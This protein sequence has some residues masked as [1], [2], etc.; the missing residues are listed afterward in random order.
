MQDLVV[1]LC[2]IIAWLVTFP[3][4][5]QPVG[6]GLDASWLQALHLATANGLI[7][8]R[9]VLFTYGPLGYLFYPLGLNILLWSEAVIFGVIIH[10]LFY[11]VLLM[12]VFK[13]EHR[14]LNGAALAFSGTIIEV[15]LREAYLLAVVIFL[16]AVYLIAEEHYSYFP[17]LSAVAATVPF[18]KIDIGLAS[19]ATI[20]LG[21]AWLYSKRYWR[22]AFIS[23]VAWASVFIIAGIALTKSVETL[24]TFVAGS[25]QLTIGF[26]PAMGVVGPLWEMYIVVIVTVSL[27]LYLIYQMRIGKISAVT[28][29]S[30]GFLFLSYKEGF[31]RQDLGHVIVFFGAWAL[32][33]GLAQLRERNGLIRKGCILLFVLLL[34]SEGLAFY[35]TPPGIFPPSGTYAPANFTETI[36]LMSDPSV[37][38]RMFASSL[39]EVRKGYGLSNSTIDALTNHTVDIFPWDVA[40]ALAYGMKWDP[41]PVFQSYQAYTSYLDGLNSRHFLDSN[42]PDFVLYELA[43]IDGRYPLFDEPL[44]LRALMCN[45]QVTGFDGN[46]MVLKRVGDHC[47]PPTVVQDFDSTFGD[48]IRVPLNQ[49]GYM[50]VQVHLQYNLIGDLRNLVYKAP[51]VY[52]Q[53]SFADGSTGTYRFEFGNAMDGLVVSAVPND[54]FGGEIKQISGITFITPGAYAFD[55]HIEVSFV[56][57]PVSQSSKQPVT[58]SYSLSQSNF[59][60]SNLLATRDQRYVHQPNRTS[61]AGNFRSI[62]C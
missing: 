3:S 25:Y 56:R 42:A 1:G 34:V 19:L 15:A 13:S 40:M 24:A 23:L 20:I 53:L 43:S 57:V 60:N 31:I 39:S 17:W 51:P 58:N 59:A 41:R 22:L 26:G 9:D 49:S 46:F 44:T 5:F 36:E 18:F 35:T 6:A 11:L 12:L 55:P 8:G 54:L 30:L 32:F 14:L 21:S 27:A 47:G 16:F 4:P 52:V 37:A 62:I 10:T 29:L 28:I 45:Y 38:S 61:I 48:T 50:F 33:F 2:F 7:F